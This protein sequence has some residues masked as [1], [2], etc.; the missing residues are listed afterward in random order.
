[1][2]RRRGT[3]DLS[4]RPLPLGGT[5]SEK[6]ST[7]KHA[8]ASSHR[9]RYATSSVNAPADQACS[10]QQRRLSGF[11][12]RAARSFDGMRLHLA[13]LRSRATPRWVTIPAI[14]ELAAFLSAQSDRQDMAEGAPGRPR[15]ECRSNGIRRV[16]S[17]TAAAN[18]AL[19]LFRRP[20]PNRSSPNLISSDGPRT[21]R[22]MTH[23]QDR[24]QRRS[25]R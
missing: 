22:H 16:R 19:E 2:D 20:S 24:S 17:C 1:V 7:P 4:S 6:H 18:R 5:H 15:R 21:R 12:P 3:R 13:P 11:I 10:A 14:S 23:A 25:L 9:R 8:C